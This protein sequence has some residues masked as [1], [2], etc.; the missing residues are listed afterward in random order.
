M[1]TVLA[2]DFGASTGR[3]IKATFDGKE[4]AYEEIHRFDNIPKEVDGHICHDVDMIFGEIKV[5][6]EKAGKV[7]SI[8]ID[9]VK[10]EVA[11]SKFQK[12]DLIYKQILSLFSENNSSILFRSITGTILFCVRM[13][14]FATTH[15]NKSIPSPCS[16]SNTCLKKCFLFD[17]TYVIISSTC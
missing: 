16:I 9:S 2:F 14:C 4:I 11:I 7:D 1:K 13:L 6:I 17:K 5:A 15:Q 12:A 10:N 8:G 3:A